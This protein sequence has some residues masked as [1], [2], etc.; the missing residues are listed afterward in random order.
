MKK[1]FVF[2]LAVVFSIAGFA[3]NTQDVINDIRQSTNAQVL[4]LSKDLIQIQTKNLPEDLKGILNDIEEGTI[5]VLSEGSDEQIKIFNDKLGELDANEYK[6][7]ASFNDDSDNI[8]VLGKSDGDNVTELV[9]IMTDDETCALI[10]VTGKINKDNA[11]KLL[12]KDT[13]KSLM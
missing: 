10:D 8:K 9:I 5:L 12:D 11:S 2:A 6:T 13:L 3:K 1:L 4:T 7:M